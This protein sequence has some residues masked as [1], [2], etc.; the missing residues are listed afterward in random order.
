MTPNRTH[1]GPKMRYEVLAKKAGGVRGMVVG[2]ERNSPPV[3]ESGG[4]GRGGLAAPFCWERANSADR[5][6]VPWCGQLCTVHET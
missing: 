6:A 2:E 3:A 5:E 1:G 4:S